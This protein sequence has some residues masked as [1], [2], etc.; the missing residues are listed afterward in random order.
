METI[1]FKL[2][3]QENNQD[4]N[5]VTPCL[6]FFVTET[7]AMVILEEKEHYSLENYGFCVGYLI[8]NLC[9]S[10]KSLHFKRSGCPLNSEC[11]AASVGINVSSKLQV[12][13]DPEPGC[14]QWLHS[15]VEYGELQ[16]NII[17]SLP[18]SLF[19]VPQFTLE[20]ETSVGRKVSVCCASG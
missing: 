8:S 19:P 2:G 20:D 1:F 15:V 18:L 11:H 7:I 4:S 5:L 17:F 9:H 6:V 13:L 12:L 16:F 3:A 10:Q 14:R